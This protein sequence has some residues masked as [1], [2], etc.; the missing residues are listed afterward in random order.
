[1]NTRTKGRRIEREFNELLKAHGYITNPCPPGSKWNRQTDHWDGRFDLE[2]FLP[3]AKPEF[4]Y[5]FQISTRWKTG[6][7]REHLESFPHTP[8]IRVIMVRKQ[9]RKG[10]ELKLY[11]YW[12]CRWSATKDVSWLPGFEKCQKKPGA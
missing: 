11:A 8:R 2:A 10:F 3:D 1:M 5:L 4:F 12:V 7:D 9:D 6:K